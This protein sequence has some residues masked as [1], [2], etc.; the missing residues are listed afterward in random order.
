MDKVSAKFWNELILAARILFVFL[1]LVSGCGKVANYSATVAY[2]AQIGLPLPSLAALLVISV[3]FMSIALVLGVATR[4]M[5]LMLGVFSLFAALIGHPYWRMTGM[6][7]AASVLHFYKNVGLIG[8]FILLY[9]TGPGKYSVDAAFGLTKAPSRA[10]ATRCPA[11][12]ALD[13][14]THA[15]EFEKSRVA[16]SPSPGIQRGGASRSGK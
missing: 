10:P 6:E 16:V 13:A 8:G 4:P 7:G 15:A 5:A 14:L 11:L 2:M 12:D 3:E 1:F 9:A